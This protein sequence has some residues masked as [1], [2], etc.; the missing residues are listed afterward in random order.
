M[1]ESNSPKPAWGTDDPPS[2]SLELSEI[3]KLDASSAASSPRML[4]FYDRLR[5]RLLGH[6]ESRRGKLGQRTTRALLV[7]PD[8][9]LLLLR[10]TLDRQVPQSTRALIGGALAYFVLPFDILPEAFVGPMGYIDDLVLAVAVLEDAFSKELEPFVRQHW[11][12]SEELPQVLQDLSASGRWLVGDNIYGRLR[13]LL[14][15]RGIPLS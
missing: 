11:S 9:F 3:S 8:I 6:V 14:A 10:L 12:G 4:S 13:R 2:Q 7:V 15:K 5:R 1:T